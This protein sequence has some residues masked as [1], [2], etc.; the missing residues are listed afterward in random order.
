MC[1]ASI[2]ITSYHDNAGQCDH[3]KPDRDPCESLLCL[4]NWLDLRLDL[5]EAHAS[6]YGCPGV[7]SAIRIASAGMIEDEH[8]EFT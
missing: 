7:E 4:Q 6:E 1:V 8:N 3:S 5:Y 2:T